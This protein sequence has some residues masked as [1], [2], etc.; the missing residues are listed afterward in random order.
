MTT[1]YPSNLYCICLYPI[2]FHPYSCCDHVK[3]NVLFTQ[4]NIPETIYD[5]LFSHGTLF[6]PVGY[7]SGLFIYQIVRSHVEYICA[8][9][10]WEQLHAHLQLHCVSVHDCLVMS[11][12]IKKTQGCGCTRLALC[13]LQQS[14]SSYVQLYSFIN[15]FIG[16]TLS[17]VYMCLERN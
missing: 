11:I 3:W 15:L 1:S 17:S 16:N 9:V 12:S 14:S 7:V 4:S 10:G 2:R 5:H 6:G 8:G 13:R